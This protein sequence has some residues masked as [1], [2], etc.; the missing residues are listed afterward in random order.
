MF[1][2]YQH[3]E[4]YEIILYTLKKMD[5]IDKLEFHEMI[6]QLLVKEG[7]FDLICEIESQ[8]F[9]ECILKLKN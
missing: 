7:M 2:G 1:K 4:K 9:K 8:Y 6:L 3:K 5:E